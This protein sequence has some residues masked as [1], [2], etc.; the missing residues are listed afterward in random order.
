MLHK[1]NAEKNNVK[2][3]FKKSDLFL[4]LKSIKKFDIIVSNPPY[5]PSNEI[6]S[7]DVEV[8]DYDPL[9]S[10]DGGEDGLRFYEQIILEAPLHLNKGGKIFF[11]VGKGQSVDVVKLLEKD[12][13]NIKVIK[14][15][16][17]INRVV[18]ATKKSKRN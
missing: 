2:I 3:I 11:E 9:I 5:I 10:L 16:N 18:Y 4:N 12:F 1:K 6:S 14:D 13:E 8:K 17:K 15:Y 7:L